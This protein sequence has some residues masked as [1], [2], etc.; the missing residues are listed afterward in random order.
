MDAATGHG[1]SPVAA[2]PHGLVRSEQPAPPQA[3]PPSLHNL[4]V[5][6]IANLAGSCP[7]PEFCAGL[8][9]QPE[10]RVLRTKLEEDDS[11]TTPARTHTYTKPKG[12]TQ[13]S[14]LT[15][16]MSGSLQT[17]HGELRPL[18]AH[19]WTPGGPTAWQL[20][21]RA[22]FLIWQQFQAAKAAAPW[23]AAR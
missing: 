2:T 12:E 14:D 22:L 21:C 16:A 20:L 17:G 9:V 3:R 8:R 15:F 19:A 13:P 7:I 11:H 4:S 18:A 1:Q 5:G 6:Q 23:W 10:D